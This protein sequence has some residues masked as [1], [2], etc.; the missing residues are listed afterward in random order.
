M[1]TRVY[2]HIMC[3]GWDVVCNAHKHEPIYHCT[4]QVLARISV[5]GD[6][7]FRRVLHAVLHLFQTDRSVRFGRPPR[8]AVH[9]VMCLD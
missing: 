3:M 9:F 5:L 4:A 1:M 8:Y 6:A 7:D 2:V